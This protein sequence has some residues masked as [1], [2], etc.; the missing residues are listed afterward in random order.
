[1]IQWRW[2]KRAPRVVNRDAPVLHKGDF[3]CCENGHVI[4]EVVTDV[5]LGT[6]NWAS[7]F[8]NWQQT[9][10][11]VPGEAY[12]PE[13]FPRCAHCGEQ[14]MRN[15]GLGWQAHIRGWR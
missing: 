2:F 10:R 13:T 9:D 4:C 14:F 7:A 15:T 6:A 3:V 11:P 5:Y 12:T 1:M 8:E